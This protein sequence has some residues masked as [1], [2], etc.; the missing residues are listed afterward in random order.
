MYLANR[1]VTLAGVAL[2]A[3]A[4][5]LAIFSATARAAL[6]T[7][8]VPQDDNGGRRTCQSVACS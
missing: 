3:L 4:I 1:T 8:F 5:C 2:L 6:R 7:C